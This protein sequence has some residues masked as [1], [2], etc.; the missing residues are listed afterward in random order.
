MWFAIDQV[1]SHSPRKQIS[2]GGLKRLQKT[3][4][5]SV[6]KSRKYF[7]WKQAAA[8]S[9][10]APSNGNRDCQINEQAIII[11]MAS[12]IVNDVVAEFTRLTRNPP[13]VLCHPGIL[14]FACGNAAA[15]A[16]AAAQSSAEMVSGAA[17][18]RQHC[19]VSLDFGTMH[20]VNVRSVFAQHSCRA[21]N[22][23]LQVC[24]ACPCAFLADDRRCR[25]TRCM[26]RL[27]PSIGLLLQR[28]VYRFAVC[29]FVTV[30][31]GKQP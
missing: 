21:S 1:E 23:M 11:A 25:R 5:V 27:T 26:C 9:D 10:N 30:L 19:W 20:L 24:P 6:I 17:N 8:A 18:Q 4:H 16:D 14:P 2:A 13:K 22:H 7:F 29:I 15:A 3:N 28:L 12:L 31:A